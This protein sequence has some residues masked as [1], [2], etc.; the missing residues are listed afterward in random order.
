MRGHVICRQGVEEE[1]ETG[2]DTAENE[3]LFADL[4]EEN[5]RE[6]KGKKRKERRGKKAVVQDPEAA[7]KQAELELLMIDEGNELKHDFDMKE[8]RKESGKKGK[9]RAKEEKQDDFEVLGKWRVKRRS[10]R[11]TRVSAV[12]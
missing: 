2:V 10:T 4:N 6:G 9:K 12:W 8:I 5:K 3:H 1:D 7:K 11:R